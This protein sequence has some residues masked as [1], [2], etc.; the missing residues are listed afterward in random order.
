MTTRPFVPFR[1]H[2][3][4]GREFDVKHP[5][6]VMVHPGVRTFVFFDYEGKSHRILDLLHVQEMQYG[7]T[8]EVDLGDG[9]APAKAA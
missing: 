6:F 7:L 8:G 1:L 9:P 3:L 4:G 5:D 2:M